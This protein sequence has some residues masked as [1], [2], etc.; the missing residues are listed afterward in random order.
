MSFLFHQETF[1]SSTVVLGLCCVQL[2]RFADVCKLQGI[3]HFGPV[4]P[5]CL[6]MYSQLERRRT[7]P[8]GLSLMPVYASAA[9][10]L[11]LI[12][13][14]VKLSVKL[15]KNAPAQCQGMYRIYFRTSHPSSESV[16]V[17]EQCLHA[18]KLWRG[19]SSTE[20]DSDDG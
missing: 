12:A 5:S 19:C 16:L 14:P 8:T 2:L 13:V 6:T 3:F 10:P 1:S 17:K 18:D 4:P 7:I 9:G 20:I 15:H 11:Y